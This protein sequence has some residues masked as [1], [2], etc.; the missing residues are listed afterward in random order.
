MPYLKISLDRSKVTSHENKTEVG[1]HIHR[2]LKQQGGGSYDEM[3]VRA[4][5][6]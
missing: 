5:Q 2:K 6:S 4:I 3:S 1:L